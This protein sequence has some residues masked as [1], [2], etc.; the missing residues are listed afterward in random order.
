MTTTLVPTE[1][2]RARVLRV[3]REATR[4]LPIVEISMKASIPT[5]QTRNRVAELVRS[6]EV[7]NVGN[8][9]NGLYRISG[10]VKE[11]PVVEAP[12]WRS[13]ELYRGERPLPMRPGALDF[14]KCGTREGD[15][16]HEWRRPML[17][18][19]VDA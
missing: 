17:I 19:R 6:G 5:Q 18:T 13:P 1:N 7:R 3:L 2:G 12:Q 16:V 15:T 4:P 8:A 10:A 14:L 9:N 11:A